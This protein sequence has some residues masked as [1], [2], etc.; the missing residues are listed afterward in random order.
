V[1]AEHSV[2][3]PQLTLWRFVDSFLAMLSVPIA[4]LGTARLSLRSRAALQLE[5]LA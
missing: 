4:I 2:L 5:I 1:A 3:L